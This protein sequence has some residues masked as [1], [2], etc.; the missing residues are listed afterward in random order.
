ME[1]TKEQMEKQIKLL[2]QLKENID[3]FEMLQRQIS[4]DRHYMEWRNTPLKFWWEITQKYKE[5]DLLNCYGD[6]FFIDE[7]DTDNYNSKRYVGRR[8]LWNLGLSKEKYEIFECLEKDEYGE[9]D[10][11]DYEINVLVD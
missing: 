8:V 6:I 5:S 10:C 2:T 7:V 1:L 3:E 11:I 4:A 9:V